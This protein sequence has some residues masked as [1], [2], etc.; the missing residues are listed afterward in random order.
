M[1]GSVRHLKP[2]DPVS[3]H[4]YGDLAE[5]WLAGG[6]VVQD[7]LVC[8]HNESDEHSIVDL[9][10]VDEKARQGAAPKAEGGTMQNDKYLVFKREEFMEF[11]QELID[12]NI[13]PAATTPKTIGALEDAIV[14]RR[15]DVFAAPGLYAYAHTIQ[16]FIDAINFSEDWYAAMHSRTPDIEKLEQL[17]DFFAEMAMMAEQYPSKKIPD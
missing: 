11:I 6:A 4:V 8:Y 14:I 2:T 16:T 7:V 9:E 17:R 1:G 15:Q 13:D 10:L 5:V 3:V 12:R